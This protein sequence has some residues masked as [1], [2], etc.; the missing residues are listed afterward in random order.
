M[1]SQPTQVTPEIFEYLKTNFSSEDDFL[2]NL[3]KEATQAGIPEIC[4]S[5]EQGKFL[6]FFLKSINAKYV[7]E[8]G[9]LA[10]YSAITMARALPEDGKLIA[11]EIH[12]KN[13]E[14]IRQKAKEAG[15]DHIIEVINADAQK[16][17]R[18]NTFDFEL[19]F[20]FIDADKKGYI[21]YLNY[22]T[23]ML[24]TG[25]IVCADNSLAFGL[26]TQEGDLGK[27]ENSVKA[28]RSFNQDFKNDDRYFTSLVTMGDGML[29]GIKK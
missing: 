29:M 25:G 28:I 16:Y 22:T 19:D 12:P 4:I 27:D 7:L 15:L 26:L 18:D 11:L 5:P 14:F 24:R 21:K 23:P 20:V 10:G 17:L 9:S 6:Q 1:S 2:L 13:A 3:K 8:V